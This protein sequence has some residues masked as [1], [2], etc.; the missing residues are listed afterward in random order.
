LCLSIL[1]CWLGPQDRA[2]RFGRTGR[3]KGFDWVKNGWLLAHKSSRD[4]IQNLPGI[5]E[6]DLKDSQAKD[7]SNDWRF[8]IAYNAALQAATAALAAADYRASRDNHRYRV[9]QS[10]ELTIGKESKFIRTFDA[11]RKKRNVSNYDIGGGVSDR[12][13]QEMTAIAESLR[14]DAEH[15]IRANHSA[16]L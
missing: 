11:F 16:L 1:V 8:A 12:E 9:I 5:V 6:R 3:G 2:R 15:W 10:L 14:E 13:V 4:E 7:V